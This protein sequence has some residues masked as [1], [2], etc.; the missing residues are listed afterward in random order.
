MSTAE[1]PKL[2]KVHPL[3]NCEECPLWGKGYA[4]SDGPQDADTIVVSR[5][6]AHGDT[7]TGKPF[8]G[9]SGK[10]LDHLLK[11]HGGSRA[12][13]FVTNV[14]L[15]ETTEPPESAINCCNGRLQA[16]LREVRA[17]RIIAA[18]AEAVRHFVPNGT[19]KGLRGQRID[20]EDRTVVATFNPAAAMHDD[21]VYPDL[22]Q[23]F[24]RALVPRKPF[25]PP[26]VEW[27][28][29]AD[30]AI[31]ILELLQISAHG[32]H[33]RIAADI[34]STGLSATSDILSIGFATEPG[35]A[36]VIGRRAF[37]SD[38]ICRRNLARLLSSRDHKWIWHNGK[39]DVKLLRSMGLPAKVD[40]DTMLLS[41]LLDERP[42]VHSLDY[43]TA[44]VLDWPHYEPE[45]VKKGKKNGFEDFEDWPLLY[46]YNGYDC[47]G[48]YGIFNEISGSVYDDAGLKRVYY[49][50]L[51]PA[52]NTFADVEAYGVIYD[53]EKAERV[54]DTEILPK[55]AEA[56][57]KAECITGRE[58][59]LNSFKQ[60]AQFIY[61]ENEVQDPGVNRR[62]AR[63]TDKA[64]RKFL[65]D[66]VP[67]A[68]VKEFLECLDD[69]KRL[70][71]LRGTYLDG[72]IK[73][74]DPDGRLRMDVLLH[75]TETGRTSNRKPN[76]QNQP[77][78]KLIRQL[79][80]AP[81]GSVI[82][83][84]DYSQAEIRTM[85]MESGDETMKE[86]YR[87]GRDFHG[88]TAAH[89]FGP[90]FTKENRDQA[91]NMDFGVFY[92]QSAF[93]FHEMYGIPLETA[94]N[95]VE[96]IHNMFPTYWEWVKEVHRATLQSGLQR[97]AFGRLR[98]FML[99]TEQNRDH[100][101]KEAVN[102]K[103]QSV[104]SD[105]HLHSANVLHSLLDRRFARI[106]IIV[107]D[108]IVFEVVKEYLEEAKSI[109]RKVMEGVPSETLGWTDIPFKVDIAFGPSWGEVE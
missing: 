37:E 40:E 54:R 6:P 83:N 42:G 67:D 3:A 99:I 109:I 36:F 4:L 60:T 16:E 25:N 43:M 82:V 102:F 58:I 66:S 78:G 61:D 80:V 52:S 65:K 14:V 51:I 28:D 85:A 15:C 97:S 57:F 35:R 71:K 46:E 84:A 87:E 88:E 41:Y 86:I 39:F 38:G 101:L 30:R 79:Y 106:L 62:V 50:L 77:R 19:V 18:G 48:S 108:S 94:K 103:I 73:R 49:D 89:H 75:G 47:C 93:S 2:R 92:G 53:V 59:N 45:V 12:R 29:D 91:K 44:N 24:K 68:N 72:L 100:V 104:A 31:E 56:R 81:P 90:D 98:R 11:M 13:T 22:I 8:S 107:H 74:V 69:F 63:S 105:F 55:I 27:T 32:G 20:Y 1:K 21:V 96:S 64:T 76:L 7:I 26:T 33:G 34:E 17:E 10:L 5:S 23:D 70:D 95:F 9:P